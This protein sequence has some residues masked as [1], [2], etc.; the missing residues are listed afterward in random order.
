MAIS[1]INSSLIRQI[2]YTMELLKIYVQIDNASIG[3][4][5]KTILT[6]P[7]TGS[8]SYVA[9]IAINPQDA[10]EIICVYSNYSVYSLFHSVDG[11][12]SWE[13][14]AVI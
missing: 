3:D 14:I 12:Q 8:N 4:P 2:F 5:P 7:P 9:D 13:K 10:E 11:G 1:T 6:G